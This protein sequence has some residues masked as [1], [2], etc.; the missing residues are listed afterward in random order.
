M[1]SKSGEGEEQKD[2]SKVKWKEFEDAVFS[3]VMK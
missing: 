1:E 2:K 3:E